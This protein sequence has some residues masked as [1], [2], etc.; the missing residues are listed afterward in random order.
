MRLTLLTLLAY[1]DDNLEPADARELEKK[2][3]ESKFASELVHRI[4][5][6]TRRLRLDAPKVDGKGDR[7]S[8]RLNSSH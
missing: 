6:C 3:E 2:I 1:L 4:R 8:T 7:K 5:T